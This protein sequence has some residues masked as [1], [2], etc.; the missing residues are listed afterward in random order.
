MTKKKTNVEEV[1]EKK[2]PTHLMYGINDINESWK[3]LNTEV[4]DAMKKFQEVLQSARQ[5]NWEAPEEKKD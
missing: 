5:V 1:E 3:V 4:A 2:T